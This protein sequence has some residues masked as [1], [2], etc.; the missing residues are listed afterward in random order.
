MQM[1]AKAEAS[2][3][4]LHHRQHA[5]LLE[6]S[7]C[8]ALML[9]RHDAAKFCERSRDELVQQGAVPM[10]ITEHTRYAETP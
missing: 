1:S 2:L 5:A 9:F 3:L 10:S 4:K 8:A 6:A 7:A